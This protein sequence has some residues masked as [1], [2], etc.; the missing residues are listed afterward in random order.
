MIAGGTVTL[1]LVCAGPEGLWM[2]PGLWGVFF[3][4][5]LFA[6]WRVLPRAIFG[7]AVY[8]LACGLA[9]L[10]FARGEGAFSPWIMAITFGGGQLMAAVILYVT[11][12]RGHGESE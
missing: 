11:L 7:V 4:L 12:E 6:S 3:S 8:Y 1:A 9:A 10:A 5:G 2:L